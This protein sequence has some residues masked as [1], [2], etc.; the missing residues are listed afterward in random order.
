MAIYQVRIDGG[1]PPSRPQR[2]Y[3]S[4]LRATWLAE[5]R[6]GALEGDDRVLDP[7]AFSARPR[8]VPPDALAGTKTLF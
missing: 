8:N 5:H 2:P 3:L 1:A 6:L 7:I 4:G